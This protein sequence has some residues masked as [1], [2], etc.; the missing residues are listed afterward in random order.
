MNFN[1]LQ[2]PD[3]SPVGLSA[4]PCSFCESGTTDSLVRQHASVPSLFSDV[5][6]FPATVGDPPQTHLRRRAL[7]HY[8]QGAGSFVTQLS[9]SSTE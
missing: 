6:V 3:R 4:G 7:D 5:D 1:H 9:K 8:P 2:E